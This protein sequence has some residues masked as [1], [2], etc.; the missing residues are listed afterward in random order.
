[1]S[2]TVSGQSAL[3]HPLVRPANRPKVSRRAFLKG[4]A[5]FAG[6][7]TVSAACAVPRA[8]NTGQ[9]TAQGAAPTTAPAQAVTE[10]R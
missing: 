6:L 4:A 9:Q 3:D 5:G 2:A 7:A 1:M 8:A 10:I